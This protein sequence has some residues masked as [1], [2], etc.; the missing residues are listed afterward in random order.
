[1]SWDDI[2][3]PFDALNDLPEGLRQGIRIQTEQ[4][5]SDT[6]LKHFD[7]LCNKLR[8]EPSLVK[9]FISQTLGAPTKIDG[10]QLVIKRSVS[11]GDL[12]QVLGEFLSKYIICKFCGK[13]D[14][15]LKKKKI[16]CAAC[17]RNYSVT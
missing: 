7:Q 3:S 17:G 14:T 2:E 9:K 12:E 11:R 10:T 6:L 5:G 16:T 1:M 15:L 8:R 13:P 4:Q